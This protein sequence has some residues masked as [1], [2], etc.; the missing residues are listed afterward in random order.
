ML[1]GKSI[2]PVDGIPKG[3][4]ITD[5]FPCQC[6]Q[7]RFLPS[8]IDHRDAMYSTPFRAIELTAEGCNR[9]IDGLDEDTLM[10]QLFSQRSRQRNPSRNCQEARTELPPTS[11]QVLVSNKIQPNSITS[12]E[13]FVT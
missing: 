11:S 13:S 3:S 7:A 12:A 1:L 5:M 4:R 6:R 9:R 2:K 8:A 10:M